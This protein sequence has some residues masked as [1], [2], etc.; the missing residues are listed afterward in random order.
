MAKF[1]KKAMHMVNRILDDMKAKIFSSVYY[2]NCE[3]TVKIVYFIATIDGNDL[4]LIGK[5]EV[6]SN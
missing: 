3:E 6:C 2:L 5:C 4:L 1:D